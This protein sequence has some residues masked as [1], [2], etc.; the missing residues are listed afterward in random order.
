MSKPAEPIEEEE[1]EPI[2]DDAPEELTEPLE[3]R[4]SRELLQEAGLESRNLEVKKT[5]Q[6]E[7]WQPTRPLT[8]TILQI[9]KEEGDV[10]S[11]ESLKLI[12]RSTP[13]VRNYSSSSEDVAEAMEKIKEWIDITKEF[14][15]AGAV[16]FEKLA[17][18]LEVFGTMGSLV[19]VFITLTQPHK[20]DPIMKELGV[21]KNQLQTL[22]DSMT[23]QFSELKGFIVE[24]QFFSSYAHKATV[25]FE[26][27]LDTLTTAHPKAKEL[28]ETEYNSRLPVTFVT[29]MLAMLETDATNPLKVNMNGDELMSSATFNKWTD[30]LN[31]TLTQFLV[32]ETFAAGFLHPDDKY[33]EQKIIEK[34][35][36]FVTLVKNWDNDYRTGSHYWPK[37]VEQ[38]VYKIQDDSSFRRDEDKIEEI[39]KGLL[40]IHTNDL[41]YVVCFAPNLPWHRVIFRPEQ[42]FCSLKRGG[43]NV[44]VYRC[45][46]Y[47]PEDV[48]RLTD[49]MHSRMMNFRTRQN[50]DAWLVEA[51]LYGWTNNSLGENAFIMV[52]T[53]GNVATRWPKNVSNGPGVFT[54]ESRLRKTSLFGGTYPVYIFVGAVNVK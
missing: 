41:F 53:S 24:Q 33:M 15:D 51:Y 19:K 50:Y 26:Y 21:L 36:R 35:A 23:H 34:I 4:R 30:V 28:F 11:Q 12:D 45:T 54:Y 18:N 5:E 17:D 44:F 32:L 22:S 39:Q 2:V 16:F 27:M 10:L 37:C 46:K 52:I 14:S 38:L 20:E 3:P 13:T 40:K 25:L 43:Y 7:H 6:K 9:A 8:K 1:S 49:R 48:K 31:S 47:A 29:E 42:V